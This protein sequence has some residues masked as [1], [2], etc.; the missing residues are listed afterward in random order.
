MLVLFCSV[1][2]GILSEILLNVMTFAI[3]GHSYSQTFFKNQTFVPDPII[4]LNI[5]LSRV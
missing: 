4:Y 5:K 3:L 1:F 2:I